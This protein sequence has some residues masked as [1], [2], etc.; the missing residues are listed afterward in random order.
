MR[1]DVRATPALRPL[2]EA[3]ILTGMVP[4][5]RV[6]TDRRPWA[7]LALGVAALAAAWLWSRR[8]PN[9]DALA[10][11]AAGHVPRAALRYRAGDSSLFSGSGEQSAP[12]GESAFGGNVLTFS[13]LKEML[14]RRAP[15]VS[16]AFLRAIYEHADEN[17]PG[18]EPARNAQERARF[19]SYLEGLAVSQPKE[20]RSL[21]LGLLK[22]SEAEEGLREAILVRERQLAP[23]SR[24]LV[25]SVPGAPPAAGGTRR[26]AAAGAGKAGGSFS[27]ELASA[28]GFAAADAGAPPSGGTPAA[29]SSGGRAAGLGGDAGL[30]SIGAGGNRNDGGSEPAAHDV[31]AKL[32]KLKT[33]GPD[34]DAIAFL[35]SMFASFPKET[36]EKLVNVCYNQGICEFIPACIAAGV[37]DE[38]LAACRNNPKCNF[39]APTPTP[40]SGG[41]PPPEPA[42]GCGAPIPNA[43]QPQG[44]S[45]PGEGEVC[46]VS[47]SQRAYFVVGPNQSWGWNGSKCFGGHMA[48]VYSVNTDGGYGYPTEQQAVISPSQQSLAANGHITFTINFCTPELGGAP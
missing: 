45:A 24:V 22:D 28:R 5:P 8:A 38:C 13:R 39:P 46:I 25:R 37:Y 7:V 36:R 27:G 15:K 17:A 42:S 26:A 23:Q 16:T 10:T 18:S 20:Q 47:N 14:H 9:T 1:L 33:S 32:A 43:T 31:A 41:T 44:P 6:R 30:S 2:G 11:A 48:G 40:G 29:E 12:A 21:A 3:L 4:F 19:T 34:K 35:E